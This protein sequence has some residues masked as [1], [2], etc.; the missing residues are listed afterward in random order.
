MEIFDS[1]GK[2]NKVFVVGHVDVISSTLQPIITSVQKVLSKDLPGLNIITTN[3]SEH[4][5]FYGW[6][7]PI[8]EHADDTGYIFFMPI[9]LES[10]D[11]LIVDE[12]RIKLDKGT[13][14]ALDDRVPHSTEG[15]G[16]VVAAF[17]GTVHKKLISKEYLVKNVLPKF[18]EAC[19]GVE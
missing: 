11:Y 17:L 13:I 16:R 10:D 3:Q 7:S 1:E 19:S 2:L 18:K 15:D 9:D 8:A 14:Y 5:Q 12:Q 4:V 6:K